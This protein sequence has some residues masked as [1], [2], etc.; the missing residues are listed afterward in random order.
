MASQW[1]IIMLDKIKNIFKKQTKTKEELEKEFEK[2][3][4]AIDKKY[5]EEGLSDEVLDM[6]LELNKDRHEN[7]ISDPTKR[8]YKNYVQ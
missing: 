4:K 1:V 3:Q 8:I 2:R 5:E 6:Q 7:N